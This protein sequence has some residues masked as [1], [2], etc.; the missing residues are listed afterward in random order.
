MKTFIAVTNPDLRK[1]LFGSETMAALEAFSEVEW[2]DDRIP[3]NSERLAEVIGEYDACITTWGSP[4]FTPEAIQAAKRLKFIGHAA[5]SVVAIVNSDIYDT[6]IVVTSANK[7]LAYSTA[8]AAVTLMLS[9]AWRLNEFSSRI[10]A[11]GWSDNSKETV[12]GLTGRTVGLIGLGEISRRVMKLLQGFGVHILLYSR[13]CTESEAASL[14]VEL[15]SLDELLTRSHIVS[16]HNTWTPATEGMIGSRELKLIQPGALLVN[17]ARG[18]IVDEAALVEELQVGRF[19]A[20]LDVYRYEPLP[21]D[22]PLLQLTNVSCMPHIGGFHGDL[23][24]NLGRFVVED[25]K[26]FIHGQEL[27]GRVTADSYKRLTPH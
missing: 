7:P 20:V 3:F 2:A 24:Q 26:R 9:G 17:T 15:C 25:L 5:G 11:G 23:K 22:H 16:L 27:E 14:G 4:K 8:E 12:L 18:A 21:A 19:S 1:L 6:E 10:K 13:Y